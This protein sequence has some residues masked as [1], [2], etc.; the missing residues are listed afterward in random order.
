MKLAVLIIVVGLVAA[1]IYPRVA[2]LKQTKF[3]TRSEVT[4]PGDYETANSYRIVREVTVAPEKVLGVVKDLAMQTPRTELFAGS[5]DAQFVTFETRSKWFGFPD[6][7][8]VQIITDDDDTLLEIYGRAR[9]G[10][11]DLGVNRKRVLR[12]LDELGLLTVAA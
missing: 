6:Y 3:H 11:S 2:P 7:T 9:F 5:I 4:A 10:V 12:W 1:L 8:T